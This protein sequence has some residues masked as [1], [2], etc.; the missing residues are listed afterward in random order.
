MP[1]EQLPVASFQLPVLSKNPQ[2][3]RGTTSNDHNKG[4]QVFLATGNW[5]LATGFSVC[6]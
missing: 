3:P 2:C 4:M 5:L 1:Q 6:K